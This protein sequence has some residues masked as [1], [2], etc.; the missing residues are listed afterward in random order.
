[1]E[2][3]IRPYG[4]NGLH[5]TLSTKIFKAGD[6]VKVDKFSNEE[7]REKVRTIIE[8]VLAEKSAY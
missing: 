6:I 3:I 8:E 4:K 2:H 1:M 5:V 7:L